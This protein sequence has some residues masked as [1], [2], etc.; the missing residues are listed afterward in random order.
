MAFAKGINVSKNNALNQKLPLHQIDQMCKQLGKLQQDLEVAIDSFAD[1]KSLFSRAA[2]YWGQWPLWIQISGG[3]L[4]ALSLLIFSVSISMLTLG[5]YTAVA[6]LLND[7]HGLL[8]NNTQKFKTIMQNLTNLLGNLIGLITNVHEQLKNEIESIQ[9]RNQQLQQNIGQLN[10]QSSTLTEQINELTETEKKLQAIIKTHEL[11]II[12]LQDANK[13]QSELFQKTQ[14]QLAEVTVQS[15]E[16]QA[17]LSEKIN[18]L[19]KIR[20]QIESEHEQMVR[21][22]FTLKNTVLSLSN[23]ALVKEEHQDLL[24]Q[25]LQEFVTSKEKDLSHFAISTSQINLDLEITQK[26]LHES[27]QQQAELRQD[28]ESLIKEFEL[29]ISSYEGQALKIVRNDQTSLETLKKLSFLRQH[30]TASSS[31]PPGSNENS[32]NL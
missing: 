21:T 17:H 2:A 28:L 31:T 25:K 18:Q 5:S 8:R 6:F 14:T 11:T 7:H 13:E 26:Q 30:S 27:L 23:P 9:A 20:I 32:L 1:N 12:L 24:K 4:L 15:E 3:F 16:T 22:V 19:E 29:L 10:K